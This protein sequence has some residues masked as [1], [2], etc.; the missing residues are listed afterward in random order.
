MGGFVIEHSIYFFVFDDFFLGIGPE[1]DLLVTSGIRAETKSNFRGY[2][3]SAIVAVAVLFNFLAYSSIIYQQIKVIF[4]G[5]FV[6]SL[7]NISFYNQE[8][9]NRKKINPQP[10][11]K[12]TT[13]TAN[14]EKTFNE[15]LFGIPEVDDI[16]VDLVL[17]VPTPPNSIFTIN[18][19]LV[20][21]IFGFAL[22][23]VNMVPR[24]CLGSKVQS[25]VV[26]LAIVGNVTFSV[27][28]PTL[29]IF[30]HEDM[31]NSIMQFMKILCVVC[32]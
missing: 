23:F 16:E 22:T 7:Q 12:E 9:Y 2:V 6:Y 10:V 31:K 20:I 14:I 25:E 24:I 21:I 28:V 3:T 5:L 30:L 32:Y 15:E 17:P 26:N 8:Y 13:P 29:I 19:V 4:D 1:I 27:L 11:I 18:K